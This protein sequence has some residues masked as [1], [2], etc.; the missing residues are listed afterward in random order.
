MDDARGLLHATGAAL[1]NPSAVTRL[2]LTRDP[3]LPL[4]HRLFRNSSR[5]PVFR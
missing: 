5:F 1:E 3:A 4:S 2:C